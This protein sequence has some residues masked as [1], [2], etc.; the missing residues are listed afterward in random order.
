MPAR[1]SRNQ[2]Q[3]TYSGWGNHPDQGDRGDRVRV[4]V[5]ESGRGSRK[6]DGTKLVMN[7]TERKGLLPLS[8]L[9]NLL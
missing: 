1:E 3:V 5:S 4:E 7:P 6:P 2:L 9:G 8:V